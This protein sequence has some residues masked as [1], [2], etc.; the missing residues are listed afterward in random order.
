MKRWLFGESFHRAF[1]L[2]MF[3]GS[4]F[5]M[6]EAMKWLDESA[7]STSES[8]V[9]CILLLLHWKFWYLWNFCTKWNFVNINI[10]PREDIKKFRYC[11]QILIPA[12]VEVMHW[13]P[14]RNHYLTVFI[15][16]CTNWNIPTLNIFPNNSCFMF[17]TS[18]QLP[19]FYYFEYTFRNVK[20]F[21]HSTFS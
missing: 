19:S 5:Y 9:K 16:L 12:E 20:Y 21:K 15:C 14:V 11:L 3:R 6:E 13:F 2:Q 4:F 1:I 7:P 8:G 18:S 10:L 17:F